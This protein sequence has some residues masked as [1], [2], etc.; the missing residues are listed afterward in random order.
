MQDVVRH[1]SG[2]LVE[3]E[4]RSRLTVEA[5]QPATREIVELVLMVARLGETDHRGWWQSRALGPAG[6]VVL[7][8]RLPRTWRAAG[9]EVDIESAR[10]RQNEVIDRPNAVHLFSDVW[11]VGRWARAW[12]AETKTS[13]VEPD[14]LAELETV[15]ADELCDRLRDR[16]GALTEAGKK[17]SALLVGRVA[18]RD[19]ESPDAALAHVRRLAGSYTALEADF[20][21]P[22]MEVE[23]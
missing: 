18:R 4:E 15:S 16:C 17:G 19:L 3:S 12:L 20:A 9:L 7:K 2:R 13:T 23:G 6:R 14:L 8:S 5:D 21:V 1:G 22:Y 11:P 10:R